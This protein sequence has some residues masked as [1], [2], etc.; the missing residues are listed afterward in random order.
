M[1]PLIAQIHDQQKAILATNATIDAR[2]ERIK[3]LAMIIS[4]QAIKDD[5]CLNIMERAA[6][7]V[8]KAKYRQRM[9]TLADLT[10]ERL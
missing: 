8:C 6:A 1:N 5:I 2:I 10:M 7:D 3:E 9:I 4:E